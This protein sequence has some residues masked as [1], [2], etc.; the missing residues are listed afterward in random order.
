MNFES[1][2]EDILTARHKESENDFVK[3]LTDPLPA[4]EVNSRNCIAQ[5]GSIAA[6]VKEKHFFMN[7]RAKR[8]LNYIINPIRGLAWSRQS[9]VGARTS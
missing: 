8:E 1:L 4:F 7:F 3:A 6:L 5:C 9:H 2:S